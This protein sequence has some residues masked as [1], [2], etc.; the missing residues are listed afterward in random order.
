MYE[1]T[2]FILKFSPFRNQTVFLWVHFITELFSFTNQLIYL[3]VYF[4]TQTSFR[5]GSSLKFLHSLW[6]YLITQISSFA[7]QHIFLVSSLYTFHF[8]T[9]T[10]TIQKKSKFKRKTKSNLIVY[11]QLKLCYV[12]HLISQIPINI[13]CKLSIHGCTYE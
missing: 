9:A 11:C 10:Y 4:I 5:L 6:I 8:I 1:S 2:Y 7:N 12:F 13:S 3:W